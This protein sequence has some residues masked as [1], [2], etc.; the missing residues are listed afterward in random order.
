MKL[1]KHYQTVNTSRRIVVE[2]HYIAK[3]H[4]GINEEKLSVKNRKLITR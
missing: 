1:K 3:L 2:K 4:M